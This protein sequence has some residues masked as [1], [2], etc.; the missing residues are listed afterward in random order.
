MVRLNLTAENA[1]QAVVKEYLEANASEVLADKI[2]NGVQIEKD[3]KVLV[4]KKDLA[5]FMRYACEEARR[6]SA[7]GANSACIKADTVFGW[8]VHFF[9]EDSIEGTLWGEDGTEYR[10]VKPTVSKPANSKPSPKPEPNPQVSF[11]DMLDSNIE[12]DEIANVAEIEVKE[13][14]IDISTANIVNNTN[15]GDYELTQINETEWVDKYGVVYDMDDVVEPTMP[16]IFSE[17][18]GDKIVAR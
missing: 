18:F 5:G 6:Q 13:L 17:M 11:F 16:S 3:G 9:E 7:K 1:E 8:A 15:S 14:K 2:N 4:N 10:P 12:I